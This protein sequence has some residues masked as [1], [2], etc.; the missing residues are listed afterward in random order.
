MNK[1]SVC[2][3]LLNAF[4]VLSCKN[5]VI[6]K[7]NYII[8]CKYIGWINIVY[9]V[10]GS[11]VANASGISNEY[12]L[13]G[14]L[15][16]CCV[17]NVLSDSPHSDY[18]F[19]SCNGRLYSIPGATDANSRITRGYTTKIK[20]DNKWHD[21]QA[22]YVSPTMLPVALSDNYIQQN[23]IDTIKYTGVGN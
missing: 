3:L 6:V 22:F 21:V 5:V 4:L 13:S 10:K 11:V 12:V 8:P 1:I 17:E 7:N 20:L 23:P 15:T 19:E 16:R 14:D 2:F 18:F 9:G